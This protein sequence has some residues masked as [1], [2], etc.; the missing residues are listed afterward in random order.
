ML[1]LTL[2]P[3]LKPDTVPV[4]WPDKGRQYLERTSDCVGPSS[5]T[6][7]GSIPLAWIFCWAST[8]RTC[9]NSSNLVVLVCVPL[10]GVGIARYS[11]GDQSPADRTDACFQRYRLSCYLNSPLH[12]AA[13]WRSLAGSLGVVL[14]DC[15][16]YKLME[17]NM[18]KAKQ[19]MKV[20]VPE[21]ERSLELVKHLQ[22][23][24]V[25]QQAA[26]ASALILLSL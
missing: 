25:M 11:N 19:S 15:S 12:A 14:I 5:A 6:G 23:R 8:V 2:K 4:C 18:D 20:K 17:S 24:Q 22:Q 16:K 21:I 9:L 13:I 10:R 7:S 3:T 1:T 26:H